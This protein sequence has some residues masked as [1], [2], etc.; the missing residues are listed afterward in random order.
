MAAT[1]M[2]MKRSNQAHIMCAHTGPL[3]LFTE[4]ET[5]DLLLLYM[6]NSSSIPGSCLSLDKWDLQ[7]RG[8]FVLYNS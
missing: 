1:L 2:K 6:N 7:V 3:S 8:V 5:G 4:A